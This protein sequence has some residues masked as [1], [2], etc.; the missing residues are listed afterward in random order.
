MKLVVQFFYYLSHKS[1]MTLVMFRCEHESKRIL[2]LF[3][4]DKCVKASQW[5]RKC[6]L[7]GT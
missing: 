3:M 1:C 5:Q 4:V 7:T 6:K 2:S